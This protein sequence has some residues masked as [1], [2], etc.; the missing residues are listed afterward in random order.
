MAGVTLKLKSIKISDS[1]EDSIKSLN[2]TKCVCP[3]L[4][5]PV[6]NGN[7]VEWQGFWD[8][9]NLSIHRH[10]DLCDI[11][12]YNYLKKYLSGQSLATISGLSLSSENYKEAI[13]ILTNEYGNTQVL[14]S[15]HMDSLLKII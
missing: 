9:F 12:R 15:A 14:V 10:E 5:F 13:E 6:F 4:K 3:K 7:P 2:Q 8:Q 1:D 11:D